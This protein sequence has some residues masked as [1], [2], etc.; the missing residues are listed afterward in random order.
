[1]TMTAR[2]RRAF[3]P[4]FIALGVI[5]MVDQ[6]ADDESSYE[7]I[8]EEVYYDEDGNE[9]EYV[10]DGDE[11]EEFEE[12]ISEYEDEIIDEHEVEDILEVEETE[13]VPTAVG[14][15]REAAAPVQSA[16][17]VQTA[18]AIPPS[19]QKPKP[20]GLGFGDR[21]KN[22]LV[23]EKKPEATGKEITPASIRGEQEPPKTTRKVKLSLRGNGDNEKNKS[24]TD[25][26]KKK[27]KRI[28]RVRRKKKK[29]ETGEE[30]A[31][32]TRSSAQTEEDPNAP[33]VVHTLIVTRDAQGREID[34][35]ETGKAPPRF[36]RPDDDKRYVTKTNRRTV[37]NAYS[38]NKTTVETS[39]TYEKPKLSIEGGAIEYK[40]TTTY[41][42]ARKTTDWEKPDW[43]KSGGLKSTAAT[44]N[45]EKPI[46]SATSKNKGSLSFTI[47]RG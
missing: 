6:H 28:R 41:Y 22:L 40:P 39:I 9:I 45:L 5:N 20:S 15:A 31:L 42:P 26:P 38:R 46:T 11:W 36:R 3:R 33:K 1:M 25:K 47:N 34:R 16:V 24:A 2:L 23:R 7:E 4:S 12:E 30:E 8:I 43:A 17:K 14:P 18:E 27:T 37:I 21:F 19:K 35:Q 32:D 10:S 29:G 13:S 44:S